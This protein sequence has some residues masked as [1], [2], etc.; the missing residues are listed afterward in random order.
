M[1]NRLLILA[2]I[3]TAVFALALPPGAS[4]GRSFT[5]CKDPSGT[6]YPLAIGGGCYLTVEPESDAM[7]VYGRVILNGDYAA[8]GTA[9]EA[10][11]DGVACGTAEVPSGSV[12]RL[13]ELRVLGA[14]ERAGCAVA[15][16]SI[17]FTVGGVPASETL[18]W[19]DVGLG[20][21]F[22]SLTAAPDH[23][24]Y[25][26]ERIAAPAPPAGL[27]VAA[28][29]HGSVCAET[30]VDTDLQGPF[31]FIAEDIFGF[32]QLA[33][34]SD[35]IEAGCGQ[36]GAAVSFRVGNI[37]AVETVPWQTG[38]QQLDLSLYGDVSCNFVVDA[39]DA[40]LMLQVDAGLLD[41]LACAAGADAN[42]DGASDALDATLVLQFA[43]GLFESFPPTAG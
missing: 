35:G 12:F 34:P 16:D 20:P 40:A 17:S 13:F 14:G 21:W 41:E 10:F 38:V 43:A 18:S 39:I 6:F 26:F 27:K 37:D 7:I 11:V 15:G 36:P 19:D 24:W 25:W 28:A 8:S 32:S 31:I 33:V 30:V 9:V 29:V 5:I 3:A 1:I 22:Q 2:V 42:G 23:A 4:A